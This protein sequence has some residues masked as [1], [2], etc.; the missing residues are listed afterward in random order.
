V[1]CLFPAAVVEEEEEEGEEEGE[2]EEK[3][4]PLLPCPPPWAYPTSLNLPRW[5]GWLLGAI[6]NGVGVLSFIVSVLL[7]KPVVSLRVTARAA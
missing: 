3:R 4:P 2:G 7:L 6:A 5:M 1:W